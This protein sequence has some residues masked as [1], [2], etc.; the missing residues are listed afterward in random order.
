MALSPAQFSPAICCVTVKTY[1]AWCRLEQLDTLLP[2][3][4]EAISPA[5]DRLTE[6]SGVERYAIRS[7]A[8]GED[9][10]GASLASQ[11][12]T[13]LNVPRVRSPGHCLS[14]ALDR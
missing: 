9:P 8:V 6:Q 13:R 11:F 1:Q 7:S 4:T 14:L 10:A 2:A 5:L 12:V 3:L